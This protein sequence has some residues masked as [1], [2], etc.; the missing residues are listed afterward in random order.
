MII[1][2]PTKKIRE[3]YRNVISE[4]DSCKFSC[5]IDVMRLLGD[6]MHL[7]RRSGPVTSGLVSF[8][9]Q[10]STEYPWHDTK[11]TSNITGHCIL[12]LALLA[13]VAALHLA[14]AFK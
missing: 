13:L 9:V 14:Y 3:S 1:T 11:A 2:V 7:S 6:P 8:F 5:P 10:N 12:K 4:A